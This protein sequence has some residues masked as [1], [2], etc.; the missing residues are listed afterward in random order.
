MSGLFNVTLQNLEWNLNPYFDWTF[1]HDLNLLFLNKLR[2]GC[3]RALSLKI[4]EIVLYP[5][6]E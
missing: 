6:P 3:Q 2:G 5:Y 4:L 1:P